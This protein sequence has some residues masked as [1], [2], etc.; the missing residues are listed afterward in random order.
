MV[1]KGPATIGSVPYAGQNLATSRWFSPTALLNYNFFDESAQIRP[2]VGVGVNFTRFSDNTL[3]A[4][5]QA[6]FG[7]P[8]S[9]TLSDSTGWAA[10]TGVSYRLQDRWN[11][12][13]SYSLSQI[14]SNLSANTSG[15]I[16][17]TSIDF[18]PSAIVLS[19]GYSF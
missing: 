4:A 8:T 16:R 7:G 19:V 17:S 6:A 14:K 11:L 1:G 9:A 18:K 13:A 2:Y 15:A 5:G 12:H 3:T 10:T